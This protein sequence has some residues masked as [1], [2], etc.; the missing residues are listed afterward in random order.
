MNRKP[1]SSHTLEALALVITGGSGRGSDE[2]VPGRY[3][4]AWHL[5]QFFQR[6]GVT[7]A[8]D[9]RIARLAIHAAS[10]VSLFYIETWN[11]MKQNHD[12]T[13]AD[14]EQ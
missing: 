3:R 14:P 4:S 8:V 9:A 12:G 13:A 7:F 10:T 11:R 2:P 5:E 6:I 1:F